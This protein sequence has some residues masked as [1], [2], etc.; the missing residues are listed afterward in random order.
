MLSSL[1][2]SMCRMMIMSISVTRLAYHADVLLMQVPRW[3]GADSVQTAPQHEPRTASARAEPHRRSQPHFFPARSAGSLVLSAT[4]GSKSLRTSSTCLCSLHKLQQC[5]A[6]PLA[7]IHYTVYIAQRT[8]LHGKATG[9][10]EI[11]QSGFGSL[12]ASSLLGVW[13]MSPSGANMQGNR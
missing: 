1:W 8:T 9:E 5:M 3:R 6:R 13:N 11:L 12:I 4:A 7:R 2:C 10:T